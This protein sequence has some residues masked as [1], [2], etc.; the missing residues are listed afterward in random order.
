MIIDK[1]NYE[2]ARWRDTLI[3]HGAAQTIWKGL[4]VSSPVAVVV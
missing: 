1:M 3:I 2:I 4:D